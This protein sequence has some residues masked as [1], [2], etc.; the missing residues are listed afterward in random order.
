LKLRLNQKKSRIVDTEK[1][2]FDFLGYSFKRA[3][4]RK[5]TKIAAYFWPSHKAERTIRKKIRK[6]TNPA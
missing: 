6:I 4:N 1:K 5:R 2:S 3:L